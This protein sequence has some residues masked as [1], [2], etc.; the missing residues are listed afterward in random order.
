MLQFEAEREHFEFQI[1]PII[2][3]NSDPGLEFADPTGPGFVILKVIVG[4]QG[5]VG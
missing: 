2:L 3:L 1:Q 4:A 5:D